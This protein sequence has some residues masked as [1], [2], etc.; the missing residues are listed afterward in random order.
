MDLSKGRRVR[1]RGKRFLGPSG[2]H[3]LRAEGEGLRQNSI[4][5]LQAYPAAHACDGVD[6]EAD[7]L[8]EA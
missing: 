1:E 5:P 3:R 4:C 8:H 7:P 6:Q 2:G